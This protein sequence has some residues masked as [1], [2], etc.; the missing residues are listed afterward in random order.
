VHFAEALTAEGVHALAAYLAQRSTALRAAYN[1]PADA[2]VPI[3]EVGAGV[4]AP[5][6]FA[7]SPPSLFLLHFTF[8]MSLSTEHDV[9]WHGVAWRGVTWR[10]VT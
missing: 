7:V 5:R 9:T 8:H 2:N 1:V 10:D 6:H 3:V 4:S